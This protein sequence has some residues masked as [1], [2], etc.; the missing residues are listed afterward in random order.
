MAGGH[1][2]VLWGAIEWVSIN[3]RMGHL[4]FLMT[5]S[6]WIGRRKIERDGVTGGSRT[7]ILTWST[8]PQAVVYANSTTVTWYRRRESNPHYTDSE[9]AASAKLGYVGVSRPG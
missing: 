1:E 6:P 8:A 2:M 7:L 4:L 5:V 9:S 3:V